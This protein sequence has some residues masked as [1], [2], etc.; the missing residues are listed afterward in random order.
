MSDV[1]EYAKYFIKQDL[2]D[3]RNS[4]DGNMKLQKLLVLADLVS[5]AE[6]D[7]PLFDDVI[8]AFQQGCVI[9]DVRLRY[10]N[11]CVGF[12]EDSL[13]FDPDFSQDVYNVL[14]LTIE[15]FGR[16]SARELS[17][18]N[19]SFDFWSRAYA[20]SIQPDGFKDKNKSVVTVDALRGELHKIR[21]IISAFRETQKENYARE[22]IN[23]IEFYYSPTELLL[24]DEL[25]DQLYCFS[26]AA[27][28]KAYSVYI[29]NGNLVVC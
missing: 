16:L 9:E 11:D 22:T 13:R 24:S 27:D 5:L 1:F 12:V 29:D 3:R 25:L 8:F 15:L 19:H 23:G 21:D 26:L 20:N 10:K 18:I 17:S 7:I 28:D 2:D 14:N 6:R 4:F